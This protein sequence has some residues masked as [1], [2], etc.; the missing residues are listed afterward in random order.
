MNDLQRKVH[1]IY[2]IINERGLYVNTNH[3][4]FLGPH[5]TILAGTGNYRFRLLTTDDK[6]KTGQAYASPLLFSTLTSLLKHGT[7]LLTGAPGIGK[8][9]GAE[10]AGHFFTGQSLDEIMQATIQGHPQQTQEQM[11][12]RYHTGKLVREGV[13]EVLP[14]KFLSSPVKIID[15][16]NRLDPDKISIIMRLIDTGIAVYGD[17]LLRS[18]EGPLFATANYTDAGTFDLPP[19]AKDRFDVATVVTSPQPW[20]LER[21]YARGDEKLNGGL[22]ALLKIPE[23]VQLSPD[24]YERIRHEINALPF[25][26]GVREYVQ[27]AIASIRFSEAASS[28]V[29]RMTKGN[30]WAETDSTT[31][32]FATHPHALT[33]NELSVRTAKALTRYAS[34]LAWF[35]GKSAVDTESVRTVWPYCTWH[36]LEPSE[37]ALNDNKEFA[38]D[39]IGFAEHVLGKV[40]EEYATVAG[41]P[42]M[43]TYSDTMYMLASAKYTPAQ[44]R[45]IAEN[46]ITQLCS[47]DSP[48]G[49]TLAKHVESMHN[50]LARRETA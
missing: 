1:G 39:R 35:S 38:N 32:H 31:A 50:E 14:R 5:D 33:K 12:A 10:F 21:I 37:K 28:E 18:T 26:E 34:A 19:P 23:E 6:K 13:E 44:R 41:V 15:E 29:A 2:Q 49:L 7:M 45:T 9:T 11:V 30:A 46:A 3:D 16:I 25:T 43:Q 48:Y 20:D 22:A 17:T 24:H 8:T 36:K 27:F 42:Q 40:D 4:V 47:W